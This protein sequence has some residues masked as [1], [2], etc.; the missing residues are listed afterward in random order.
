V[1]I[2]TLVDA[3]IIQGLVAALSHSDADVIL[4]AI[5]GL[6]NILAKSSSRPDDTELLAE[7]GGL[8]MLENLMSTSSTQVYEK[9]STLIETFYETAE[10]DLVSTVKS[11]CGV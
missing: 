10:D 7:C 6:H 8:T 3:H 5:E 4:K 9:A 1:H 11:L 2:A